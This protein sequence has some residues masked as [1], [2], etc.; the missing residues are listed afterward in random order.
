MSPLLLAALSQPAAS[1]PPPPDR[2]APR[3]A[4]ELLAGR[5]G[6][7][8]RQDWLAVQLRHLDLNGR[9]GLVYSRQL[10]IG[11]RGME[12]RLRGPALGRQRR[13]GLSLE[14]RF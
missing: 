13:F 2:L 1:D 3:A 11:E 10:D 5:G 14:A 4:V 9:Y 7:A 12:F 6:A 8:L